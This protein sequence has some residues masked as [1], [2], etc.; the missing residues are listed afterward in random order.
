[1]GTEYL[2]L[3]H[4]QKSISKETTFGNDVN[5]KNLIENIL[6]EIAGKVCQ[7]LRDNNFHASTVTIKIRYSDFK[8]HHTCKNH[9]AY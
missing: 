8:T 4:E 5:S 9:K 2:S 6:F 3:D 7:T 1:M